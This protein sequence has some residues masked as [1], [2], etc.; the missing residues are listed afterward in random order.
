MEFAVKMAAIIGRTKELMPYLED[1]RNLRRVLTLCLALSFPFALV[2][3]AA[4][5][6]DAFRNRLERLRQFRQRYQQEGN[7]K[8]V[9]TLGNQK[10][11]RRFGG[12]REQME[13][14][15]KAL[16]DEAVNPSDPNKVWKVKPAD[17]KAATTEVANMVRE[18][19]KRNV[20]T[21]Q[22][23][24]ILYADSKASWQKK[25]IARGIA[26]LNECIRLSPELSFAYADRGTANYAQLKLKPAIDDFTKAIILNPRLVR[27][28]LGRGT[29]YFK[30]GR[31]PEA[32]RDLD[33]TIANWPNGDVCYFYRSLSYERLGDY[34]RAFADREK[35]IQLNPPL[36]RY[37]ELGSRPPRIS[38]SKSTVTAPP[39][40]TTESNKSNSSSSSSPSTDIVTGSPTSSQ[41][42]ST[43]T[44]TDLATSN[45]T[46]STDASTKPDSGSAD[47]KSGDTSDKNV[48]P[49]TT[50][51]PENTP[52]Q[53]SVQSDPT[54]TQ[55][56]TPQ[57][58]IPQQGII[59]KSN[60]SISTTQDPTS[61][62]TTTAVLAPKQNQNQKQDKSYGNSAATDKTKKIAMSNPSASPSSSHGSTSLSV[63]SKKLVDDELSIINDYSKLLKLNPDDADTL[64]NRGIANLTIGSFKEAAAD[65]KKF[66]TALDWRSSAA[67][68]GAILCSI[69]YFGSKQDSEAKS[70]LEQAVQHNKTKSWPYPITQYLLGQ[71]TIDD[72]FSKAADKFAQT[73]ARS[74]IG[75]A[76]VAKGDFQKGRE[77][78]SWLEKNGDRRMQDYFLGT[79]ALRVRDSK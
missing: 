35:A 17:E 26:D 12:G 69:S 19:Q 39:D 44:K 11:E 28:H 8:S 40:D 52:P 33:V 64:Y 1:P 49:S 15:K 59:S 5:C 60:K 78:L 10:F 4:H 53:Q 47:T 7:S 77:C 13:G 48:S 30:L 38:D 67:Q 29:I 37:F 51:S 76:L 50:S 71:G 79:T 56:R 55:D 61:T 75:L 2:T 3:N 57:H 14:L 46:S 43:D 70:I 9:N 54:K 36:A 68:Y 66:L 74:Y 20:A 65:F 6:Q 72:V 32:I 27:P 42:G 16:L 21:K 41:S 73:T 63:T 34:N 24:S 23:V 62:K 58:K 45:N 25:N 18:M 31:Y 22:I